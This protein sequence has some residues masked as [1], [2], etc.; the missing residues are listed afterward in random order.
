MKVYLS[1]YSITR[2]LLKVHDDQV[3]MRMGENGIVS[4]RDIVVKPVTVWRNL[5]F[6]YYNC[7]FLKSI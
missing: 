7:I 3:T 4:T 2:V 1:N 5:M 6:N